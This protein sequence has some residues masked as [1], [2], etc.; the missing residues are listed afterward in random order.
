MRE[1]FSEY[2]LPATLAIIMGGM[3]LSL[4]FKDFRQVFV[5]PRPIL[6]GLFSQMI[7]LPLIA[8]VLVGFTDLDPYIK[9][10]FILIAACPGGTASNLV[11]HLLKGNLALCVSL[12]SLNSLLIL[13]TLPL[14]VNIA[15]QIFVGTSAEIHLP[16]S[17]T[18]REVFFV[19]AIPVF[20]GMLIRW[21]KKEMAIKLEK[22][23][24][25]IMTLLL[26]AV[27]V[28]VIFFEEQEEA[29]QIKDYIDILPWALALNVV[30]MIAGF[31]VGMGLKTG[32]KNSYTISIEVGLQNSALA[33]FVAKSLLEN[34]TMAVVAVIYSSF[35]FFSTAFIGWLLKQYVFN[36]YVVKRNQ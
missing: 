10:G 17:S 36:R 32:Y 13:F 25:Y 12:S 1:L 27:F 2:A 14:Y 19:I 31:L 35:T 29:A 24:R 5:R 20:T 8:F 21:W 6:T 30:S 18:M 3:G 11:T 33:I 23:L 26:L 7:L 4:E 28:V 22:P 16:F 9:V 15:L 34:N